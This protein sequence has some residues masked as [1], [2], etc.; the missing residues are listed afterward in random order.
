MSLLVVMPFCIGDV[1]TA[2]RLITWIGELDG[3]INNPCLLV[4][5][6]K[7]G[8][9]DLWPIF[10]AAKQVFAHVR[11]VQTPYALPDETW[12]RGPAWMF[13]IAARNVTQP[14]LWLEPD[15]VPL[16]KGWL[17]DIETA[18]AECG[19]AF[20]GSVIAPGKPDLP[21]LM[22]SGTCVYPR[23]AWTR[24]ASD[25]EDNSRAWDVA[26]AQTMCRDG[27]HSPLF[28]MFW[29]TP[30][31][32][33]TF[34]SGGLTLEH[35]PK[36]AVL[37]HRCKDESLIQLL[38]RQ[39]GLAGLSLTVVITSHQRPQM[40][41]EAL[42]S[43]LKAGVPQVVIVAT[44]ITTEMHSCLNNI[45]RLYPQ[46]TLLRCDNAV[47]SNQ[48]WLAGVEAVTTEYAALLHDDDLLLPDYCE[49]LAGPIK[50]RAHFILAQA[51]RH[52]VAQGLDVSY[53]Q[54]GEQPTNLLTQKLNVPGSLSISPVR[55]VFKRADLV[56]WLK[57]AHG[58]PSQCWL[59]PGFL[60]GNDLLIW[61]SACREYAT[62]ENVNEPL[63]SFGH[64][65]GSTTVASLSSQ[66]GKL[67]G[68]Y[69]T[70]RHWF[71]EQEKERVHLVTRGPLEMHL[72]TIVL[73]GA[74]MIFGHLP[75]L[76][77][78]A[79]K[80]TWHIVEGA[81]MPVNC[82]AWCQPQVARL[83]RDGTTEVLTD[84]AKHPNIRI[85]KRPM[86]LG[87]LEMVN[88]PL[89]SIAGE[90]VLVQLDVDEFWTTQ[91][92]E[93]MAWLFGSH[94]EKTHAL[95]WCRYFFGPHLYSS[96]KHA[97]GNNPK[98]EWKRA[99]RFQPGAKFVSHEP[100]VM[101]REQAAFSHEETAS[102]GLIF[103]HYAYALQTQVQFKERFYGY[104]HA[105]EQWQCLQAVTSGCP[106]AADFLGWLPK[107]SG[108]GVPLDVIR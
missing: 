77:R 2:Q 13:Q 10:A 27:K 39:R 100:P 51:Q 67:F 71:A 104:K 4:A 65:A 108:S 38:R 88:I 107:D 103:D 81:A 61:L 106:N 15:C 35:I 69:D 22:M 11:L 66:D 57:V 68:I 60:V 99:W 9:E 63:V 52:G 93:N 55:G 16:R 76:N 62:F 44:G 64:W 46:I 36:E 58:L 54:A 28:W 6:Y 41:Q 73:D 32:P 42:Q 86:W 1:E 30:T 40:L 29:G 47:T 50:K 89:P 7:L 48:A 59:R 37:F 70:T 72:I 3:H 5:D 98:Q 85:Y 95:F 78:L 94:T 24:L 18:Y 83:S 21:G 25:L 8:R 53:G 74:P 49:R 97:Y 105:V 102:Q 45:E 12:P 31:E 96:T 101:D 33:P 19:K 20:M 34:G 43:C 87:K 82:T 14:F 91:Q 79:I 92:L 75:M 23:D 90:C 26:A 80:W 56:R 84:L 17:A